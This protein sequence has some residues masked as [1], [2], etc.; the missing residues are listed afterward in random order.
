MIKRIPGIELHTVRA[1]SARPETISH[2]KS[3]GEN[4]DRENLPLIVGAE[5]GKGSVEDGIAH[6]RSYKEIIIHPRCKKTL[7]EAR[8][9]SYKVDRLS[10]DV[11][12]DIVDA[13]NHYMDALR[14]A[15]E[16]VMK[17]KRGFFG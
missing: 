4:E 16:P 5:K 14:Y 15:L 7:N 1:D 17:K 11:L 8:L 2:V 6:L 10:G 9:Y 3:K 13:H 12:T